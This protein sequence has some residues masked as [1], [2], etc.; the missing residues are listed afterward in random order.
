[1][2]KKKIDNSKISTVKTNDSSKSKALR[3]VVDIIVIVIASV[4]YSLGLHVFTV[5]NDIAAGGVGGISTIIH[6]LF[7]INVGLMYGLINVPLVIVG[8][9]FLGKNLMIK[10]LISVVVITFSTDYLLL[11]FPVY[12]N[13]DKVVASIFGGVLMGAGLGITFLRE[14]T[15]GGT[16]ITNK[17]INKFVPHFSMGAITMATDVVIVGASVLVFNNIENGLYAVISIFVCS[18]V[19][20]MF[21]YGTFEGKML[22][23]F[24]DRYQEIADIIMIEF[25][26]GVT[27]LLAKGAYSGADKNVICCA[28]H[29]NEYAKIK[30]KVKVIDPKAFIIISNTGEVLGDGFQENS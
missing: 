1:M 22:L 30:R 20:D 25:N 29:K 14:G 19:I 27:F 10:T 16:D 26:R 18:K 21:L 23:I 5:P 17:I 8:F 12:E 2:A 9:I 13:G 24:S 28:V 15:S 3:W 6:E 7:D 11:N 4:I